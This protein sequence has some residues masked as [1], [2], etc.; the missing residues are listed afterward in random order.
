MRLCDVTNHSTLHSLRRIIRQ[1]HVHDIMNLQVAE[2]VSQ[3]LQLGQVLRERYD[4]LAEAS[5]GCRTVTGTAQVTTHHLHVLEGHE[6]RF[7]DGGMLVAVL[8]LTT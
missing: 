3:L 4:V 8:Q 7:G 1:D 2:E 6:H 5:H